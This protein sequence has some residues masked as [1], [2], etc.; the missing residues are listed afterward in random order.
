MRVGVLMAVWAT[1]SV[2]QKF[3]KEFESAK[4]YGNTHTPKNLLEW[5]KGTGSS[6]NTKCTPAAPAR[7][8]STT[9]ATHLAR[10]RRH[11]TEAQAM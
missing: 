9:R 7:S 8:D 11:V 4:A 6:D 5:A 10:Y 1:V 3:H 2:G